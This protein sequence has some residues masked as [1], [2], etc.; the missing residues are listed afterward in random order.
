MDRDLYVVKFKSKTEEFLKVGVSKELD[1]RIKSLSINHTVTR[2][3]VYTKRHIDWVKVESDIHRVFKKDK[4]IPKVKFQGHT[5]CY[6]MEMKDKLLEYIKGVIAL[7]PEPTKEDSLVPDTFTL[8]PLFE[9]NYYLVKE[10]GKVEYTAVKYNK[11][12]KHTY[13]KSSIIGSVTLRDKQES[14]CILLSDLVNYT[15]KG[16]PL[17][18]WKTFHEHMGMVIPFDYAISNHDDIKALKSCTVGEQRYKIQFI[19][20]NHQLFYRHYE[21]VED[22]VLKERFSYF[23]NL[24]QNFVK[25]TP[26]KPHSTLKIVPLL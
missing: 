11:S 3:K 2:V 19:D 24:N 22:G 20:D 15:L 18:P 8:I 14:Y 16:V 26:K 1:K 21:S 4:Y 25:W 9:N 13:L 6:P 10:D 17:P 23:S 5:E 7:H 12:G